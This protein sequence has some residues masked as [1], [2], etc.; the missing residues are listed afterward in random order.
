MTHDDFLRTAAVVA[1]LALLAAPYWQTIRERIAEAAKAA[2]GERSA[3]L[4]AAG[5]LVL[6]AALW[7]KI[8]LP[9]L[10]SAPVVPSVNVETPSVEMQQLVSPVADALA[11]LP[12]G[13]R[14]L[15]VDAW[16]KAALVVAGDAVTQEV[17]FTDTRTL[18]LFTALSLDIAWRRIGGHQPGS[19][20]GLRDAVEASYNTAL[21]RDVVPV[22]KAIRD[23]YVEFARAVA[24][25][26]VNKG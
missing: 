11:S 17:A 7:G 12:M 19:I 16:S 6:I 20:P 18:R 14:M 22:D 24:W 15:W 25:A 9:S 26:G 2:Y 5:A 21:G 13:D 10:P 8:P 4:R 23:R 3:L 1:G